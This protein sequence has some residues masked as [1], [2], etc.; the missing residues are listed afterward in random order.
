VIVSNG[1]KH[2]AAYA[3]GH[4]QSMHVEDSRTV[5]TGNRQP[6]AVAAGGGSPKL[7]L[8]MERYGVTTL[9]TL[10]HPELAYVTG[11]EVA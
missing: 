8:Q 10:T 9:P 7:G 6:A 3:S 5:G 11:E 2:V 1:G 4:W